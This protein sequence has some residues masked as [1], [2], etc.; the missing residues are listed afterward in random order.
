[1]QTDNEVDMGREV[2]WDS[3]VGIGAHETSP[4]STVHEVSQLGLEKILDLHNFDKKH[5]TKIQN[6]TEI[7]SSQ[8]LLRCKSSHLLD[9]DVLHAE[10]SLSSREFGVDNV[11]ASKPVAY[12]S[13][14]CCRRRSQIYKLSGSGMLAKARRAGIGRLLKLLLQYVQITKTESN[15]KG[16][17]CTE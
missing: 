5:I 17:N 8:G 11:V 6:I 15:G 2:R 10:K 1:M 13:Y 7:L 3:V 4:S 12:S 14:R 16:H 9:S